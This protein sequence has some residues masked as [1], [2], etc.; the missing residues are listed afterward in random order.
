MMLFRLTFQRD[1]VYVVR[2]TGMSFWS[3]MRII[4]TSPFLVKAYTPSPIG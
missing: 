2:S 4:R 3:S 1:D